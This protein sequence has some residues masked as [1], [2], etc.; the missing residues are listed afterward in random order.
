MPL[1][2]LQHLPRACRHTHM[3]TLAYTCMHTRA[4][5]KHTLRSPSPANSGCMR[6]TSSRTSTQAY[7]LPAARTSHPDP[8]NYAP[9][10]TPA[11]TR[12]RPQHP[13]LYLGVRAVH[14]L[15][16]QHAVRP[17][18]HR[19]HK[20]AAGSA[21]AHV[22]R[23]GAQQAGQGR[24]VCVLRHLCARKCTRVRVFVSVC[25]RSRIRA[26]LCVFVH[27]RVHMCVHMCVRACVHSCTKA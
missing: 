15:Q 13:S 10:P 14:V 3:H 19:V 6:S 4:H 24:T 7:R 18:P 23:G 1:A 12:T 26:H 27:V 9:N 17:A 16:N 5:T 21:V 22:T 25:A 8:H 2:G 11:C 20:R